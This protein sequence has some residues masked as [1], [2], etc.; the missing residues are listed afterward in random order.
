[1]NIDEEIKE[2]EASIDHLCDFRFRCRY[3]YGAEGACKN[4]TNSLRR[5]RRRLKKLLL[6][7]GQV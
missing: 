4:I 2:L 6:L 7:K 1:M 5:Y 3:K